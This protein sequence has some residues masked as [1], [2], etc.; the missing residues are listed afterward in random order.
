MTGFLRNNKVIKSSD[1]PRLSENIKTIADF[2]TCGTNNFA[3]KAD[4]EAK[5]NVEVTD[6]DLRELHYVITTT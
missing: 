3:I 4:L 5:Y 1:F 6:A 2:Y